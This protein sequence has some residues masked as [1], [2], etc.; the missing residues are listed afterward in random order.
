MYLL[1]MFVTLSVI[2]IHELSVA[3]VK[4]GF[5]KVSVLE[6]LNIPAQEKKWEET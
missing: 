4:F 5:N 3:F 2:N 1:L 6:F